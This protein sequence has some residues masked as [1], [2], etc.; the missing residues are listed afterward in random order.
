MVFLL[1]LVFVRLGATF[2]V[3]LSVGLTHGSSCNCSGRA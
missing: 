2:L 3:F 1:G